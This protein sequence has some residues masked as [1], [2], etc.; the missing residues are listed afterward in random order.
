L[1]VNK[2]AG[3]FLQM[4][5]IVEFRDGDMAIPVRWI[6]EDGTSAQLPDLTK[7]SET[8]FVK[9]VRKAEPPKK[10]WASHSIV[11]VQLESGE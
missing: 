5:Q 8:A 10:S 4:Y 9:L 6:T 2:Q 3:L 11:S 1:V 7:L